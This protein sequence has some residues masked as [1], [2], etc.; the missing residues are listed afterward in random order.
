MDEDLEKA[1]LALR[2]YVKRNADKTG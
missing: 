1:E 2:R